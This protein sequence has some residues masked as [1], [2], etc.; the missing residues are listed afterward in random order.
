MFR[1]MCKNSGKKSIPREQPNQNKEMKIADSVLLSL[2][3]SHISYVIDFQP[4]SY[5]A[6]SFDLNFKLKCFKAFYMR[7]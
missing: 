7:A 2:F 3:M 1:C 5:Q 4:T 6:F